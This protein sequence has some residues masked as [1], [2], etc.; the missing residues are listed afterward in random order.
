[1]KATADRVCGRAGGK[2]LKVKKSSRGAREDEEV[3]DHRI[4]TD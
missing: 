3:L 4:T 2:R 1:M